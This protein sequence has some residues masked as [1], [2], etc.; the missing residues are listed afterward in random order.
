MIKCVHLCTNFKIYGSY[1]LGC[2]DSSSYSSSSLAY[3]F[4]HHYLYTRVCNC[5][6]WDHCSSWSLGL[7]YHSLDSFNIIHLVKQFINLLLIICMQFFSQHLA[8]SNLPT[9][10]VGIKKLPQLGGQVFTGWGSLRFELLRKNE[11]EILNW[12][13]GFAWRKFFGFGSSGLFWRGFDHLF[14][15]GFGHLFWRLFKKLVWRLFKILFCNDFGLRLN[16]FRSLFR[17]RPFLRRWFALYLLDTYRLC[18]C[19]FSIPLLKLPITHLTLRC[20]IFALQFS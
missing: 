7:C 13:G 1:S 18:K 19:F 20:L 15:K 5:I 9:E 4:T 2:L 16:F 11:F 8:L 14:W 17:F 10:I 3:S 6:S 12:M